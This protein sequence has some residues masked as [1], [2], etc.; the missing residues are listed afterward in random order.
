MDTFMEPLTPVEERGR[1]WFKREDLFL[2]FGPGS[3]NGSKARQ[4]VYLANR[5]LKKCFFQNTKPLGVVTGANMRSSQLPMAAA[6]AKQMGV[7]CV[8]VIGSTK[9]DTAPRYDMVALADY[10]GAEFVISKV[11]YNPAIQ[12]KVRELLAGPLAGWMQLEYGSSLDHK[13]HTPE[14]IEMFHRQTAKQIGNIPRG[15]EKLI[16]PTGSCNTLTS[17]MYGLSMHTTDVKEVICLQIGPDKRKWTDERLD[18]IGNVTGYKL[19]TPRRYFDLTLHWKYED[20]QFADYDGINFHP[21]Y[22]GKC[23]YWLVNEAPELINKRSCFWLTGDKPDYRS[24]AGWRKPERIK[25]YGDTGQ[26][27]APQ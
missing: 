27:V 24:I 11:G 7:P 21:T 12:A 1:I 4:A 9:P 26:V 17:V 13:T 8:A 10:Y 25:L 16:V 3:M 22:E 6:L 18:I 23:W 14:E 5:Y 19:D 2:P 15:I 20:D